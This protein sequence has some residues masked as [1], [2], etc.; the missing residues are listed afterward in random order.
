M[1]HLFTTIGDDYGIMS[2]QCRRF[3]VID[4]SPRTRK[5]YPKTYLNFK[6]FYKKQA[7]HDE[8]GKPLERVSV[9]IWIADNIADT[10]Y[11][12][13]NVDCKKIG[14][15]CTHPIENAIDDIN[16]AAPG[17]HLHI[18]QQECDCKVRISGIEKE[19][20]YTIDHIRSQH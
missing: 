12:C 20:A 14:C 9:P 2:S 19:G 5:Q 18:I 16:V 15:K 13:E 11:H 6:E 8:L 17:L 7:K 1:I 3:V 10:K 4:P